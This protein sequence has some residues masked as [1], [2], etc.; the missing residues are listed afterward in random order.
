MSIKLM[1]NIKMSYIDRIDVSERIDV[2]KTSGISYIIVLSFNQM[3][4]IDNRCHALLMMS[5]NL[6]DIAILN[7][8]NTHHCCLITGVSKN[9]AIKLF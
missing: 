7:M 9:K 3:S 8:K 6:S 4:T 1:S 5:M 2:D